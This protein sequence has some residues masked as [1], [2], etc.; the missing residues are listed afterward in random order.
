MSRF[1]VGGFAWT[2]RLARLHLR[3]HLRFANVA[4]C[5]LEIAAPIAACLQRRPASKLKSA[6]LH[7]ERLAPA[8]LCYGC[9]SLSHVDP[10]H[11]PQPQPCDPQPDQ[12]KAP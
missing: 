3:P 6:V 2:P 10:H 11:V 12:P 9:M 7:R 4:T 5:K 1:S 8:M